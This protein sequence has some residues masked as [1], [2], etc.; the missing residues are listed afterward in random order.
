MEDSQHGLSDL[1]D[2]LGLASSDVDIAAFIVEH[3]PLHPEIILS[4]APF[5]SLTQAKFLR[6]QIK[7]DADWAVTIDKFDTSLR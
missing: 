3:R 7:A 1:F 6:E 2:Q 4:E 5:W